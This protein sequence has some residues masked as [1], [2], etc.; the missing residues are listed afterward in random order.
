MAAKPSDAKAPQ[1]PSEAE[2]RELV[3]R[4]ETMRQQMAAMEAQREMV[5]EV[6]A[7]TRRSLLTLEKMQDAKPGDEILVPL[8]AGA[9]VHATLRSPQIA[10]ASLGTGL[11]AE[12]PVAQAAERLRARAEQLEQASQSLAA[13]LDKVGDEAARINAI[14]EAYYGA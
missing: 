14:L 3:M 12:L 2:L 9:F 1:G 4:G 6:L 8:G 10:L 7:E 13:D 11:H 5:S